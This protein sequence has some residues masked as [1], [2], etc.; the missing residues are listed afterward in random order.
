MTEKG[1]I[2]PVEYGEG[3]TWKCPVCGYEE[4]CP[5]YDS[6]EM[7]YC[8]NCSSSFET[9]M[10]QEVTEVNHPEGRLDI[11]EVDVEDRGESQ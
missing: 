6:V 8:T 1:Q 9:Y 5:T 4:K 11:H 3:D 7:E 2:F 10:V